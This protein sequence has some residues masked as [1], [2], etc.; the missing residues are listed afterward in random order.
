[1]SLVARGTTLGR[2]FL[3]SIPSLTSE[4]RWRVRPP[5][6]D[7]AV[8]RRMCGMLPLWLGAMGGGPPMATGGRVSPRGGHTRV[9]H[10]VA[11]SASTMCRTRWSGRAQCRLS[12]APVTTITAFTNDFTIDTTTTNLTDQMLGLCANACF[13]GST[14]FSTVPYYALNTPRNATLVYNEDRMHPRPVI[15]ADVSLLSGSATP[16]QYTL[17]ATLNGTKVVFLTGDTTIYFSGSSAPVRLAGQFDANSN[18]ATSTGI[19]TLVVT[20]TGT[21]SGVVKT[22]TYTQSLAIENEALS[23]IARGWTVAG[24]QRLYGTGPYLITDGTGNAVIFAT[25]GTAAADY[26]TLTYNAGTSTYTRSY[27]DGTTVTFNATGFMTA[28]TDRLGMETTYRYDTSNR[29]N[30]IVDPMRNNLGVA[31]APYL[32]LIYNTTYGLNAV[33]E[34]GGPGG[35]GRGTGITIATDSSI[36]YITDPGFVYT[37]FTYDAS[38]RLSTVIDRRGD[39]TTYKYDTHSWKLTELDLPR[40]A[41][42]AGGGTTVNVIPKMT[43]T[44]WQTLGVPT[45]PTSSSTPATPMAKSAVYATMTDPIGRV[46]TMTVDRWGQPLV[47]T[48]PASR[49]T[50]ITRSGPLPTLVAKPTGGVDTIQY[51]SNTPLVSYARPAGDSAVNYHYGAKNQIDSIWGTGRPTEVHYL[52]TTTGRVD[53]LKINHEDSSTVRFTYDGENRVTV[54]QDPGNHLTQYH[55]ATNSGNMDSVTG[56]GN[57]YALHRFDAL[58]RD[59]AMWAT[60][61]TYWTRTMYDTVNRLKKTWHVGATNDTTTIVYDSLYPVQVITP[62]GVVNKFTVNALGWMTKRYDVGDTLSISYRYDSAGRMTSFTN[63]RGQ[64]VSRTYDALDRITGQSGTNVPSDT[65]TYSTSGDTLTAWR[66]NV[67]RDSLYLNKAGHT[68]SLIRKI[69]GQRYAFLYLDSAYVWG[70]RSLTTITNDIGISF[71]QQMHRVD[72]PYWD[73]S[74]SYFVKDSLTGVG[75]NGPQTTISPDGLPVSLSWQAYI[76]PSMPPSYVL[77]G[78]TARHQEYTEYFNYPGKPR[79]DSL[80]RGFTYDSLGRVTFEYRISG[81]GSLR[82]RYL[83]DN[84]GRLLAVYSGT[85]AACTPTADTIMGNKYTSCTATTLVDSVSYDSAG[86]MRKSG[87]AYAA[88]NR[89]TSWPTSSGT[90]MYTYDLDGNVATRHHGSVTDTLFWSATNQLDSLHSGGLSVWYEYN[91]FGQLVRRRHNGTIDRFFLWDGTQLI[92]ELNASSGRRAQYIY[93]DGVDQPVAIATDSGGTSVIRNLVQDVYGNVIGI[94]RDTAFLRYMSYLPWGLSDSA[95][96]SGLLQMADTNRLAWKGLMYEGDSTKLYYM[97][98]RWYDPQSRRFLSEDPIGIAGGPTLYTFGG[99]DPVNHVDPSGT[100]AYLQTPRYSDGTSGPSSTHYV[101]VGQEII[102]SHQGAQWCGCDGSTW[103]NSPT[104]IA[105]CHGSSSSSAITASNGGGAITM[106]GPAQP[107]PNQPALDP[108][109]KCRDDILLTTGMAV[110]DLVGGAELAKGGGAV[111]AALA[112]QAVNQA[113]KSTIPTSIMDYSARLPGVIA[114]QTAG[115]YFV[116]GVSSVAVADAFSFAGE[117]L[118]GDGHNWWSYIPI[119]G[120]ATFNGVRGSIKACSQ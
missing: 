56:P 2:F 92:A 9:A 46:T 106:L 54:Y 101:G 53:S 94:T 80:V 116:G 48:D 74:S 120:M 82:Y 21:I 96:T 77:R 19:Y 112:N 25:L 1:M 87:D 43:D 35:P 72:Y 98:S 86:N 93:Q 88:G 34:V 117:S 107:P 31:T 52:N 44:P 83:Y 23:P 111:K 115:R 22:H 95:T 61:A 66:P 59:S 76:Y 57:L 8:I 103:V 10:P 100:C 32:T 108:E 79:A 67:S 27:L 75:N 89:V 20:V 50:T 69:A 105:D 119:P 73:G 28:L 36:H 33:Q 99:N 37:T 109:T 63:R 64:V 38:R 14:S 45:S 13:A 68:D 11:R 4:P 29:L 113:L 110:F 97:R 85:G 18:A 91:S 90:V 55:Y 71:S 60:G 40:I 81:T 7:I 41:A 3:T 47:V 39:T 104:D 65:Y 62:G 17:A 118:S 5:T 114:Q 6:R 51:V 24:V 102:D 15:Y 84:V 16:T 30:T 58:G 12:T 78:F 49:V 42:D 26:S 70:S